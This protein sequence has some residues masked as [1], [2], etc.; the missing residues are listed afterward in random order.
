MPSRC[1]EAELLIDSAVSASPHLG[2]A[3]GGGRD[4]VG[5]THS[6]QGQQAGIKPHFVHRESL[7]LVKSLQPSL[8]LP[9][10]VEVLLR[11]V[12]G[13]GPPRFFLVTPQLLAS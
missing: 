10:A 12:V 11:T 7:V 1:Q 6:E 9:W 5:I 4:R 3:G 13:R 2:G 8:S